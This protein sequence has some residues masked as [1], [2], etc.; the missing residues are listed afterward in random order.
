MTIKTL[1]ALKLPEGVRLPYF[2]GKIYTLLSKAERKAIA[3]LPTEGLSLN[4]RA[5][6]ESIMVSLTSFP[7]RIET[8]GYA[9]KSLFHQTVKPDR[10]VLWLAEEQFKNRA[11]PPLLTTLCECGL[12]IRFCAG[13][14]RSHKKYFYALQAQEENELVITYDD[15]LI[16]P[17]DSIERLYRMHQEYPNCIICNRG[18]VAVGDE[19]GFAPYGRWQVHSPVG[20]GEPVSCV[21]PSTGGGT[22]YPFGAV[23][24]DAFSVSVM[25]ENAFTADDLWIRFMS[26]RKGTKVVKTRKNHRTFTTVEGSQ[27][28]SLQAVNCLEGENDRVLARLSRL[29]PE[30]VS[31]ILGVDWNEKPEHHYTGIQ[32]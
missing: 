32:G 19:N 27:T 24:Q 31:E 6:A 2:G 8:V 1:D 21:F 23:H 16:F 25:Q 28:E 30:A 18:Q 22:L 17:E 3:K 11:L 5:R 7:A 26:A 10:I 15:D 20:V 29:Y 13:D 14:L 4:T 9:I 12:E